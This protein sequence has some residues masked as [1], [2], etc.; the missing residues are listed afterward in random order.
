MGRGCPG[1]PGVPVL[2]VGEGIGCWMGGHP[3]SGLTRLTGDRGE[4]GKSRGERGPDPIIRTGDALRWRLET[5]V[6]LGT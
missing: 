1:D 3:E 5:G 2:A 6:G 4:V